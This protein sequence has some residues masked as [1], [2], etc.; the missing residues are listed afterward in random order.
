MSA[1]EIY[2]HHKVFHDYDLHDFKKWDKKMIKLTDKHR[3]EIHQNIELF[4]RHRLKFPKNTASSRGK[5]IWRDHPASNILVCDTKSGNASKVKPK[6]LWKSREEYQDFS[7]DDFR[8]HIY[9]EKYRQLA[10]PYW[11]KKRNKAALKDHEKRVEQMQQ[12]WHHA[13]WVEDMDSVA[14]KLKML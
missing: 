11:Q 6:E 14:E 4:K 3:R 1:E 5:C 8:K 10:G 7:L 13:K 9:Q 12:E 2:K